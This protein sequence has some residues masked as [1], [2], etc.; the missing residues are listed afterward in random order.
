MC[1]WLPGHLEWGSFLPCHWGGGLGPPCLRQWLLCYVTV[2]YLLTDDL[3]ERHLCCVGRLLMDDWHCG[4]EQAIS[5]KLCWTRNWRA[6][7]SQAD[8]CG[9]TVCA[10]VEV[11]Q[12]GVQLHC[13]PYLTTCIASRGT[14]TP[15]IKSMRRTRRS[16]CFF[17]PTVLNAVAPGT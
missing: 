17:R 11:S 15:A 4:T 10:E 16:H 2:R 3:L 14:G 12:L 6:T 9:I 1:R 13:Q 7:R 5:H 8:N